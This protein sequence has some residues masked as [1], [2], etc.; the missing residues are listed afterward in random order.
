MKFSFAIS[1]EVSTVDVISCRAGRS[2][3]G[4]AGL[5]PHSAFLLVISGG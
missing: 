2:L 5:G 4:R 3:L 1:W